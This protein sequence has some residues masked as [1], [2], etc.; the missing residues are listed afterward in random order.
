MLNPFFQQ[1]SPSEQNLIQDLINEQLR[2]YGVEVYYMPREY[3]NERTIIREVIESQFSNAAPIEAYLENNEGY[4]DNTTLLSKFGI[5]ST[6]EINLIISQD[7]FEFYLEPLIK[8]TS[9]TKLSTRPKEG[10]LIYFPL[11]DRLFEIKFVEHEKP[12]YQLQKNYVYTLKCELFRYSDEV[13]DT[14]ISE[15]D[16][17]LVGNSLSGETEDGISSVLGGIQTLTL[18]G[19]A[20]T[21]TAITGIVDGGIRSITI[22]KQGAYFLTTPRVAISSAPSGGITGVGTAI[23]DRNSVNEIQLINAGAGYTIAP[24]I[25]FVS[26]T[27]VGVSASSIIGDGVIGIITV[28]SGGS[29]YTTTPTITFTNEVFLTGVTTVSAAATAIV[30]AGGS[31]TEIY[32]TN[33]GVGYS[34][35]P[36]ISIPNNSVGLAGTFAFNEIVTGSVSGATARVRTF[37]STTN[38][39]QIAN[40]TG[41]FQV[42][43]TLT[44]GTSGATS[45]IRIINS[46]PIDDGFAEN[47]LIEFEA[48]SILDFTE[49]NPFGI[50]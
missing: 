25:E 50:P 20:S 48:D 43:E 21:A 45:P 4:S 42:N 27:G 34:I 16:D 11:G 1:G 36:T 40:V 8:N 41:T 23:M 37:N 33:S 38:I 32:I 14:G 44:G 30:S 10:D 13:I 29:G 19:V 39:L 47:S 24:E 9:N 22:G 26:S 5:Q 35:A 28:T 12:F 15:I 6:Q 3:V 31:I 46:D 2:M 49:R 18:V 17:N 7:R